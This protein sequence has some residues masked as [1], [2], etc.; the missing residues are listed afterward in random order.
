MKPFLRRLALNSGRPALTLL[1]V[2]AAL[3]AG[4][5]LWA[6]YQE[7]PWTRDGRVRADVVTIAPDVSGLVS[8]VSVKDNQTVKRGETLFRI[9]AQRFELALAQADAVA[10]SRK[11]QMDEARREANRT[12]R[13]NQLSVSQETQEQRQSIADAAAAAYR[14][15]LADRAVAELNLR[16]SE[17]TSPVDG[18]VTNVLLQPG[19]YVTTGKGVMALVDNATLRIEGYFEETKLPKIHMGDRVQIR[20]MGEPRPLT[21]HVE[22]IAAGIADRERTDSPDLLANINPTFN[23]VRLAQRVPVRVKPDSVPE[24]VR[25]ILGR[26]AT[27]TV[28]PDSATTH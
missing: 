22:S 24:G 6:Y 23:W 15:S 2:I 28:E 17:V 14:E 21:G 9:D 16:R 18:T 26:T 1:I 20:L 25:L 8:E 10:A 12:D 3:I 5:Y 13:L 11:A 7:A 19:D 4:R 27:V